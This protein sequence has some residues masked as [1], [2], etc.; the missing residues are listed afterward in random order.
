MRNRDQESPDKRNPLNQRIRADIE[1]NILS[2]RWPPGFRIPFERELMAA[3]GCSRMTV[4][5]ALTRLVE[6][7]LIERRR[8][9]GSFV[10][11]PGTHS[12]FLKLPDIQA[13]IISSQKSY[14][15]ELISLSRRV[16]N[17]EDS[18]R[19]E[20]AKRVSVITITCRHFADGIPF[21]LEDRIIN[22]SSVPEASIVDFASTPPSS[23][24]LTHIPWTES[25]H[26]ISCINADAEQAGVLKLPEGA[27][28]LVVERRTKRSGQILTHVRQIFGERTYKLYGS[29][30][31]SD[32]VI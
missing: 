2:G 12:T 7:G 20:G 29:Y 18:L 25:E 4:N 1:A 30:V 17:K 32:G 19:L 16:A 15:Y 31:F 9:L 10:A 21:A 14:N 6:S 23:W 27:A 11:Y 28:C 3:Y 5:N 26:S 24:L 8:K 22:T 13:E